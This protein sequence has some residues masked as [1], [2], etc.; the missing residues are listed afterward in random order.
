MI[1]VSLHHPLQISGASGPWGWPKRCWCSHHLHFQ[2][3]SAAE[4]INIFWHVLLTPA[5][6]LQVTSAVICKALNRASKAYSRGQTYCVYE[7][8][9]LHR[10][11]FCGT[12]KHRQQELPML[13]NPLKCKTKQPSVIVL[14]NI[15]TLS[16]TAVIKDNTVLPSALPASCDRM[17]SLP[18]G[19][20][21]PPATA[22][23]NVSNCDRLIYNFTKL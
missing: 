3:V 20:Q 18:S 8:L 1:S 14:G 19:S 11:H 17:P 4:Q 12:H 6:H 16:M 13:C 7:P 15:H 21:H 22:T 9:E 23:N 5:L 2:P 10:C